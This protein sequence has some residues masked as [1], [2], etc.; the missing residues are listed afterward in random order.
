MTKITLNKRLSKL[1]TIIFNDIDNYIDGFDIRDILNNVRQYIIDS[2]DKKV[3]NKK[4]FIIILEIINYLIQESY[5]P[6]TNLF[7]SR[8]KVLRFLTIKF[9]DN[10]L[11]IGDKKIDFDED[12]YAFV[13]EFSDNNSN[14]YGDDISDVEED[15]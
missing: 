8:I 11:Y 15:E 13:R 3:Y 2:I 5:K 6:I 10:R 7:N 12:C 9:K 14:D 1:D 4:S